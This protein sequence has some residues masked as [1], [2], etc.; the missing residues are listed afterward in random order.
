[1]DEYEACRVMVCDFVDAEIDALCFQLYP[2][3]CTA[4]TVA[5]HAMR[6]KKQYLIKKCHEYVHRPLLAGACVYL[7]GIVLGEKYRKT[8][9]EIA[10]I[11]SVSATS[12]RNWYRR[13]TTTL[14]IKIPRD[15]YSCEICTRSFSSKGNLAMHEKTHYIHECR[16]CGE[17][18]GESK[19]IQRHCMES[20][21]REYLQGGCYFRRRRREGE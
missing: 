13:L 5:L 19:N 3:P 18:W 10:G 20:H 1:M 4:G 8:Q 7:V 11:L 12:I 17:T 14:P 6:L 9:G 21:F 15:K 16:A 2:E